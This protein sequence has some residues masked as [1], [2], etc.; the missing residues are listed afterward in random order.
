MKKRILLLTAGYPPEKGGSYNFF[1]EL[2]KRIPHSFTVLTSRCPGDREYDKNSDYVIKRSFSLT[3]FQMRDDRLVRLYP[4]IKPLYR[5]LLFAYDKFRFLRV[6]LYLPSILKSLFEAAFGKYD[7]IWCGNSCLPLGIVGPLAK[8]LLGKEYISFAYGEE[9]SEIQH[10]GHPF[11]LR[12]LRLVFAEASMIVT[13]SEPSKKSIIHLGIPPEK[14]KVVYPGVDTQIFKPLSDENKFR[15][16]FAPNGEKIILSVGRLIERKGFDM[17]IE[18]LPEL[19]DEFGAVKYI[20]VGDGPDRKRLEVNVKRNGLEGSVIFLNRVSNEE[21]PELYNACDLFVMPN[22]VGKFAGDTE[23]FGIVFIEASACGKPVIAGRSGG[24][25]DA[26]EDNKTGFLV[27]P[28]SYS[29]LREKMMKLIRNDD[30]AI[31]M[32]RN[33]LNRCKYS[34]TWE[35]ASERLNVFLGTTERKASV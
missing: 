16:R 10:R 30:A 17:V 23:G 20:L 5:L 25:I 27:N 6:L 2:L 7:S 28:E 3:M 33:G 26:V 12:L 32:G 15:K 35:K 11:A 13:V 19:I 22:R 18:S 31:E 4:Y 8:R 9:I 1:F 24:A 21:L 29:E 14:I 34:F